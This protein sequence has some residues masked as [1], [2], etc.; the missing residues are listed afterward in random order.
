M[1]GKLQDCSEEKRRECELTGARAEL[2]KAERAVQEIKDRHVR[3]RGAEE[4]RRNQ[5]A[6][7]IKMEAKKAEQQVKEQEKKPRRTAM[8]PDWMVE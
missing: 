5:E 2:N 6:G 4:W 1:F 3:E 8:G 7:S